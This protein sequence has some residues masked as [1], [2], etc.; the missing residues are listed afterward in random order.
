MVAHVTFLINQTLFRLVQRK[1]DTKI[2]DSRDFIDLASTLEMIGKAKPGIKVYDQPQLCPDV[3]R[4]YELMANRQA[5]NSKAFANLERIVGALSRASLL[6]QIGTC[7]LNVNTSQKPTSEASTQTC[8]EDINNA[9]LE[10]NISINFNNREA[11]STQR[12][13]TPASPRDQ[14]IFLESVNLLRKPYQFP[15]KRFDG[16]ESSVSAPRRNESDPDNSLEQNSKKNGFKVFTNCNIACSVSEVKDSV[17]QESQWKGDDCLACHFSDTTNHQVEKHIHLAFE[18]KS[19]KANDVPSVTEG[20]SFISRQSFVTGQLS[21]V[22]SVAQSCREEEPIANQN[23]TSPTKEAANAIVTLAKCP[24]TLNRSSLRYSPTK[25]NVSFALNKPTEEN[26]TEVIGSAKQQVPIRRGPICDNNDEPIRVG[27]MASDINNTGTEAM[28]ILNSSNKKRNIDDL[29]Y[30]NA[31]N[32]TSYDRDPLHKAKRLPSDPEGT[33]LSDLSSSIELVPVIVN[34][35]SLQPGQEITELDEGDTFSHNNKTEQ[36][37]GLSTGN[38]VVSNSILE[39][40]T[41]D[42]CHG[43]DSEN[44]V[45]YCTLHQVGKQEKVSS[46]LTGESQN[47]A[48]TDAHSSNMEATQTKAIHLDT[49]RH[50]PRNEDVSVVSRVTEVWRRNKRDGSFLQQG[51]NDL[52]S[53]HTVYSKSIVDPVCCA[54]VFNGEMAA[55]Q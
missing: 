36:G 49:S 12:K 1:D 29:L 32:N 28:K 19:R 39:K 42:S 50:T 24:I 30:R 2:A 16:K 40:S 44:T 35:F 9:A 21:D 6:K 15:E 20:S 26:G 7:S 8:E 25:L 47:F 53:S 33:A 55:V 3:P 48:G 5:F 18:G 27:T 17:L 10:R 43:S 41:C 45:R 37:N 13:V 34:A 14:E 11:H 38:R 46:F 31:K 4:P 23:N 54:S 52:A 22:Y 51:R